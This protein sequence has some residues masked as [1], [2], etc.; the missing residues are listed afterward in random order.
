[1]LFKNII[2]N[3][4]L[5][6]L[7]L[8]FISPAA[9]SD[10]IGETYLA[11]T[12]WYDIQHHGTCGR[13]IAVDDSGYISVVWMNG[14]DMISSMRHVYCNLWNPLTGFGFGVQVDQSSRAGYCVVDIYPDGRAFTAFHQ[15][16]P[17]NNNFHSAAAF[18]LYPQTGAF[19]TCELPWVYEFGQ[20]LE[21]IWPQMAIDRGGKLHF[22]STENPWGHFYNRIYYCGAYFDSAAFGFTFDPLEQVLIDSVT[23]ISA[24][25]AASKV[26]N[27][28]AIGWMPYGVTSGGE[29]SSADNDLVIC[30]S[31]NG[32][33]WDFTDTI[34]V[35]NWIPPD[36]TL[37]PDTA[38]ANRD[39]LRCVNDMCLLFDNE[40]NLHVFFTTRAYYHFAPLSSGYVSNNS[41]IW[42]WDEISQVFSLAANGWFEY[43]YEFNEYWDVYLRQPSAGIDSLT[44]E[45]YCAYLRNMNSVDTSQTL[46]FPYQIGDTTQISDDGYPSGDVWMTKSSDDGLSWAEGINI[47]NT[48]TPYL[49]VAGACSSE[50]CPSMAF[51]VTDNSAHVFYVLDYDCGTSW[52]T[53][54]MNDVI[55]QRTPVAEIPNVPVLPPYPMHCDSTGFPGNVEVAAEESPKVPDVFNLYPPRPNPFNSST[56]IKF[57]LRQEGIV[58]L[59]IFDITGREVAKIID[60]RYAAGSHEVSFEGSDLASGI[61][62]ARLKSGGFSRTT[63]LLLIK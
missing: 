38:A 48:V 31:E 3:I 8:S 19:M 5:S 20:D 34:N 62:F 53:P 22:V 59:S 55:Y 24:A 14:L 47:S 18:D 11:G 37:L 52:G 46:P 42:H 23:T 32:T 57:D 41:Y 40:D 4:A 60:N 28:V 15:S 21:V 43:G 30:I 1:M 36:S 7:I 45:I 33:D 44:G 2:A 58:T 10:P 29:P 17:Y 27:R 13:Q 16:N 39:T 26:S 35:T 9:F 25:V 49:A 61:Y 63:K 12:T 56:L 51:N 54:T 6:L 50:V